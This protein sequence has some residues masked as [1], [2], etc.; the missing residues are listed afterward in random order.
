MMQDFHSLNVWRK[1]HALLLHVY[2]VSKELPPSEN[3]GLVQHLRRAATTLARTIAEGAGRDLPVE[4]A[5]DLKKARAAG[6]ELEYVFLLCREL[7][8]FTAAVHDELL[9]QLVEVRRMI[10]GLLPKLSGTAQPLR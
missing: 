2:T 5:T 1:A 10:S 3:F 9:A 4:F 8:F 6:H 7:V